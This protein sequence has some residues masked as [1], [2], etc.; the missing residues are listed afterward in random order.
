MDEPGPASECDRLHTDLLRVWSRL[1][2]TADLS[3]DDDFFDKGGDSLLATELI[4][5]M[6]Q[7]TATAI[8]ETLLFEATTIREIAERLGEGLAPQPK[9]AVHIGAPPNDETPLMFFHGDVKEGGFYLAP[10]ARK[11]APEVPLIAIAPHGM[12]DEPIPHS[13]EAMAAERLPAVLEIQPTGP[14]RLGGFCAGAIVAFE[15]ARLL[16]TLGHRVE[17]VVLV[18]P[19]GVSFGVPVLIDDGI[20]QGYSECLAIYRPTFLAVPIVLFMSEPDPEPW[21]RLGSQCELRQAPGGHF[22][23]I[24]SRSDA[25]AATLKTSLGRL[26]E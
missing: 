2:Q 1:L 9:I 17:I 10:L 5:E 21:C 23:W 24:T 12:A 19:P 15:T 4:L 26:P 14:Y 3:I 25:L 7:L 18:N 13:I 11:L 16:L 20:L 8:P 22:D 6:Q